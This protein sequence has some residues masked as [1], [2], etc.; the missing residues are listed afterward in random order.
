V[1]SDN[2]IARKGNSETYE[3]S[4]KE[5]L[6]TGTEFRLV[7]KRNKWCYIE[8]PDERRCWIPSKDVELVRSK[9]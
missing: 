6:H 1:I 2:V 8:L 9:M 5:P 4:F 7:E 3:P